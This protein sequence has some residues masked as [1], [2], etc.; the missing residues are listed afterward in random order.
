MISSERIAPT[1]GKTPCVSRSAILL[2]M[3]SPSLF[4]SQIHQQCVII[5]QCCRLKQ[6]LMIISHISACN[7]VITST[8]EAYVHWKTY[9]YLSQISCSEL[10]LSKNELFRTSCVWSVI[11]ENV[12]SLFH[13][14]HRLTC[15][16]R[17]RS[18]LCW[19]YQALT[20]GSR[21]SYFSKV[22]IYHIELLILQGLSPFVLWCHNIYKQLALG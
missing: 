16:C 13:F 14:H 8:D 12:I 5:Q 10:R 1:S 6:I 4:F 17:R 3:R 9:I 7:A 11:I 18:I 15:L 19:Q 20:L 2:F 21:G 22:Y